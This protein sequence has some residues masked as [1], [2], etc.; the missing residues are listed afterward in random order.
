L[1]LGLRVGGH[2]ALT[3]FSPDEHSELLHMA[4]AVDDNKYRRGYYYFYYYYYRKS[5]SP[6]RKAGSDF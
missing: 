1:Q 5:M 4:G 2:L 3:D 6:E